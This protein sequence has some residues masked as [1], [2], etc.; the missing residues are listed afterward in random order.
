MD[1]TCSDM[2]L[3]FKS[4]SCQDELQHA[5]ALNMSRRQWMTTTYALA[6]RVTQR[7]G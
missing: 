6:P 2:L 4:E 5:D 1:I 3:S 7:L